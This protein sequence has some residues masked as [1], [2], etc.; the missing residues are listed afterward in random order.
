MPT[1]GN[2]VYTPVVNSA[3]PAVPFTAIQSA[4]FNALMQDQ[5]DAINWIWTY[6]RPYENKAAAEA[7]SV[8]SGTKALQLYGYATYGDSR[9]A[10]LYKRVS[11]QPSHPGYLRTTDRYLPNGSTDNTNGGYWEK[12]SAEAYEEDFGAT[13]GA[14]NYTA[15]YNADAFA[16][17]KGIRLNLKLSSL[18]GTSLTFTSDVYFSTGKLT[19]SAS[20]RLAFRGS[21]TQPPG[22]YCLNLSAA[23]S[24]IDFDADIVS[25]ADPLGGS[26]KYIGFSFLTPENLGG[27][28]AGVIA[29]D[30]VFPILV[31][32][33]LRGSIKCDLLAGRYHFDGPLVIDL[34]ANK[35][36]G[37]WMEGKGFGKTIL[38]FKFATSLGGC[39][40]WI[41][42]AGASALCVYPTF[43]KFSVYADFNGCALRIGKQDFTDQINEM[44]GSI[45]A[46]NYAGADPA[47]TS[48]VGIEINGVYNADMFVIANTGV[49]GAGAGPLLAYGTAF[50]LRASNFSTYKG[51]W[52]SGA[53]GLHL[54]G[55]AGAYASS[56]A[57]N[58]FVGD[59]ENNHICLQID[60]TSVYSNTCEAGTWNWYTSC[61]YDFAGSSNKVDNPHLNP[62]IAITAANL[63]V[64]TT[65]RGLR[66]S[67]ANP[68]TADFTAPTPAA[69]AATTYNYSARDLEV[70]IASANAMSLVVQKNGGY[71]AAMTIVAGQ[72][73]TFTLPAC[74][75]YKN[76]FPAAVTTIFSAVC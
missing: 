18:V 57:G 48:A 1:N 67:F 25:T 31:D 21:V 61:L 50:R 33:C 32:T 16:K 64:P 9:G 53:I 65:N 35:Y 27:S 70:Y 22:L 59:N 28:A 37:F 68:T 62:S 17:A 5:A 13:G 24:G 43:D 47:E 19:P 69:S 8:P 26:L 60:D 74:S 12:V 46:L 34:A 71:S 76:T 63:V 75:S 41:K 11:A 30:T 54:T 51:S 52:G 73:F 42:I 56:C 7:T 2:G 72:G 45:E 20:V 4:P 55:P 10:L 39:A 44:R 36:R 49:T 14:N 23:G 29:N 38:D 58:H 6:A 3:S 66:L 15:L 40:C